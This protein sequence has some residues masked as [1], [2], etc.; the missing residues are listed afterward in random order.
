MNRGED[1]ARKALRLL[2]AEGI[3]VVRQHKI[4]RY[5]TDFAIRKARVAIEIDGAVHDFPSRAE[6]DADRQSYIENMGWRV[7]R[8]RSEATH[9]SKTI[10]DAVK[11]A[12]PLPLRGG[13]RGQGEPPALD[14]SSDV[15][16]AGGSPHPLTP[17]PQGEGGF[18]Q[19]RTRANRKLPPRR[20][21]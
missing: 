5:T 7:V 18:P 21:P 4:G 2:R 14:V 9:D 11:A 3:H 10:I 1:N 13:G 19:R 8:L 16:A 15:V 17:S 12:L 20:K 6:Y